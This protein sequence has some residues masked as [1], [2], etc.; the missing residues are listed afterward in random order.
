MGIRARVAM[1]DGRLLPPQLT[2]KLA[3]RV[4]DDPLTE[5]ERAVLGLLADGKSNR[6]I[7]AEIHIEESTVKSHLKH[8]REASRGQSYRSGHRLY[9]PRTAPPVNA[10][11]GFGRVAF[12]L[13]RQVAADSPRRCWRL[14][15]SLS[16]DWS[17]PASRRRWTRSMPQ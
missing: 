16:R 4:T 8:L 2:A 3:R 1:M 5:R 15:K 10:V 7:G 17:S 12:G 14:P 9:A 11:T 13:L 6:E